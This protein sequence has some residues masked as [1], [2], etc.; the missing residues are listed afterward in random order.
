MEG[1][2]FEVL[3]QAWPLLL[4]GLKVTLGLSAAAFALALAVGIAVGVLRSESPL[5]KAILSPYVEAF[6]GTPLLIQLFFIYYG[7]PSV[8]VTLSST[9][10]GILGLGLNGGAYISEIIRGALF[11][12][13][14]GQKEAATAL[15]LS[16]LQALHCVVL[17]Q[18]IRVATPPLVNAFSALLKDSSLVSVL[19]ITE[20]TRASQLIYTRTFRAFEVYLAVGLV[21]FVLIYA[22][23]R[24]SRRLEQQKAFPSTA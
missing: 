11:S 2:Q 17:P 3:Q 8:G 19:A 18:A 23:S 20:L 4:A 1:F 10:A 9:T 13:P 12:V 22:V 6:R 5:F 7:L 21:Y 15:G 14:S 24:L 16:R